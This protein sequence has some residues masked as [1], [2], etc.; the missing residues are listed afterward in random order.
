M[1][2]NKD[3]K[4]S[5]DEM[6]EWLKRESEKEA[7]SVDPDTTDF[8]DIDRNSDHKIDIVEMMN[9]QFRRLP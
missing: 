9:H 1:D 5:E 7:S 4:I 6:T 2:T 8:P 3:K